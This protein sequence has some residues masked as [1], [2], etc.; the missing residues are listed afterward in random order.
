MQKQQTFQPSL[1]L[2]KTSPIAPL[3]ELGTQVFTLRKW[4]P[5]PLLW[6]GHLLRRHCIPLPFKWLQLVFNLGLQPFPSASQHPRHQLLPGSW[7]S[8]STPLRHHPFPPPRGR[9]MPHPPSRTHPQ[10]GH[11]LPSAIHCLFPHSNTGPIPHPSYQFTTHCLPPKL[12]LPLF[13]PWFCHH[14]PGQRLLTN[15]SSQQFVRPLPHLQIHN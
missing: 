4:I 15:P 6:E 9:T 2:R 5:H 11:P 14:G 13:G 10:A 3:F 8:R 1:A 12:D 7:S